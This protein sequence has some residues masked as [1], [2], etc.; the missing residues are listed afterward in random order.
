MKKI[1]INSIIALIA[2]IFLASCDNS[3][4]TSK[5]NSSTSDSKIKW[6]MAST[7]PGNL[8][9]IGEGGINFVKRE[10]EIINKNL[11]INNTNFELVVFKN[12]K[13]TFNKVF[14]KTDI[15]KNKLIKKKEYLL[16][17]DKYLSEKDIKSNFDFIVNSVEFFKN[18]KPIIHLF[19][20]E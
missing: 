16:S 14:Y 5:S 17:I 9:I 7:F 1:L 19:N 8:N 10:Y 15:D 13:I 18:K 4:E 20:F 3:S 2:T 6:K 11:N 12:N